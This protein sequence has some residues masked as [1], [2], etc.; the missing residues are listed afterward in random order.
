MCC[1]KKSEEL[2]IYILTHKVPEYGLVDDYYVTPLHCG[3]ALNPYNYVC[4]LCDNTGD[5]ISEKNRTYLETTGIYWIWKNT[6][7]PFVGQYQYRRRFSLDGDLI[8]DV[9][10]SNDIIVPVHLRTPVYKQYEVC[11]NAEDLDVCEYVISRDF[12]EFSDPY[13]KYILNGTELFYSNGFITRRGIYNGLCEFCF[14]VLSG[15]EKE[16]GLNVYED[17]IERGKKCKAHSTPHPE[18]PWYEYQARIGGSLFERLATMY[19]L[20]T[21]KKIVETPYIKM[22]IC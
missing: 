12:A 6:D 11:H 15:Y 7:S 10:K 20:H 8:L 18:I 21:C 9:L 19:I 2:K 4:E 3:K 17:W 14:G 5:N 1:M 16:L 13:R 22:E